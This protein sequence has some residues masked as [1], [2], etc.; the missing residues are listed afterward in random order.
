VR[1][2]RARDCSTLDG[3]WLRTA[4]NEMVRDFYSQIGFTLSAEDENTRRF[5][6]EL[7]TFQPIPTKIKIIRRAYESE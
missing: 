3:V 4:K 6:L 7:E 2:A 5:E 1:L